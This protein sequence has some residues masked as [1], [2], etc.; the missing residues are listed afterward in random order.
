MPNRGVYLEVAPNKRLVFTD[1]YTSAWEP[2]RKPSSGKTSA[3]LWFDDQATHEN[4]KPCRMR[5]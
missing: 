5:Q 1:T 4:L 3:F 2:S